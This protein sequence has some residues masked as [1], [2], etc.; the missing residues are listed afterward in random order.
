MHKYSVIIGRFQ[1]FHSAHLQLLKIALEVSECVIVVLGSASRAKTIKDPWST[2]ERAEMIR[3][4]LIDRDPTTLLLNSQEDRVSFVF[5]KD[6]VYNDNMWLT[7]VQQE[8]DNITNGEKDVVLIGHKK[9]RS[10]FYLEMFPQWQFIETGEFDNIDATHVRDLYFKCDLIGIKRLVSQ[11]VFDILKRDMM[12]DSVELTDEFTRLKDEY[13]HVTE[14]KEMWKRAP[15]PPTFVT[16]DAV[17]IKSGHVLVVRRKG[18]PGKGLIAL[19]GGFVNENESLLVSCLRE[20][21]EETSIRLTK[22]ELEKSLRD[23][24]VFDHPTRSL[25]GRT[26]THAFCFNLG[27]GQLPKVKGDDDA[28]KAWWMPLRDVMVKED[29]FF[30]DHAHIIANFVNKF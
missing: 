15:Y 22:D 30:E 14:Y 10:S 26:I 29:Q 1:P 20:L 6:Y 27:H 2:V 18:H 24:R 7:A 3:L 23:Q 17:V 8:I 28:D 13:K 11:P 9:D 16:T 25:R 12:K 4:C 5:A 21:K 19:P